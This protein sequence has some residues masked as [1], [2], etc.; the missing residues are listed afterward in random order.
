MRVAFVSPFLFRFLRGIERFTVDLVNSLAKRG[1]EVHLLTWWENRPWPWGDLQSGV[2]LHPLRLP[3]YFRALWAGPA[4]ALMLARLR[5]D[6]INLFFTWHGEEIAFRLL[7]RWSRCTNLILHYPSKQVPHR[8]ETLRQSRIARTATRIVAVSSYVADGVRD[9]LGRLSVIIP[10][11][12]DMRRFR[13]PDGKDGARESLG[14]SIDAPVL[15][16]V[17]AL[18]ERKGVHRVLMALPQVIQEFPDLVYLVA[19]DGPEKGR[20]TEQIRALGLE[21]HV[22]LLGAVA[23][24]LPVYHAADVFMFLSKGEASPLALLEAMA[25]GLP[26]IAARRRPLEEFAAPSGTVFVEDEDSG[27]VTQAVLQLT[28]NPLMLSAMGQKSRE[29]A[30][31]HFDWECIAGRYLRL[32]TEEV[33]Q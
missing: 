23:D 2:F 26:V 15:A 16:T 12:V 11:G 6:V 4:Y 29:H 10:S 19:G 1:V 8:Y 13:P 27:R 3:R 33:A 21:G 28:H 7:P 30:E 22:R 9:W 24:P 31:K 17:A 32:F 25:C 20:L 5:P 14:I 18:E